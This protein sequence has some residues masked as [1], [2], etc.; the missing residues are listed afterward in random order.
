MN[1]RNTSDLSG[2]LIA[3][4]TIGMFVYIKYSIAV[5]SGWRQLARRYRRTGRISGVTW[6]FATPEMWNQNGV[7]VS[8][9]W[10]VTVN[11]QGIGLSFWPP[12]GIFQPALFVP[13]SD[14]LISEKQDLK[15]TRLSQWLGAARP[16]RLNFRLEPPISLAISAKLADR[17]QRA[18][19]PSLVPE[20]HSRCIERK[21]STT[22]V[23]ILNWFCACGTISAG[24]VEDLNKNAKLT[25][26]KVYGF[27]RVGN[28]E[29]ALYIALSTSSPRQ[30]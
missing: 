17:I 16:V 21:R 7:F 13:W 6:W 23:L 28:R 27:S 5:K 26:R 29:K 18:P 3:V 19:R 22:R 25:P 20:R 15:L 24:T 11:K 30:N 10:I 8:P 4:G 1:P 9:C 2:I 12:V 14:I